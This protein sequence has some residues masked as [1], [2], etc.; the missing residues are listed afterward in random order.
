MNVRKIWSGVAAHS[1]GHIKALKNT[2]MY[3][4]TCSLGLC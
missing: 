3:N 1:K 4:A 2:A